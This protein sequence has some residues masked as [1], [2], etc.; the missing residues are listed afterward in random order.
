MYIVWKKRLFLLGIVLTIAS[1][2]NLAPLHIPSTLYAAQL[3][4]ID[5]SPRKNVSH[6]HLPTHMPITQTTC[7][8]SARAAV[9][10]PLK[11]GKRQNLLYTYNTSSNGFLIR[12]DI[13]SGKKTTVLNLNNATISDARISP[14]GQFILFVTQ[15]SSQLALQMVRVDGQSLQ[16]LYCVPNNTE[17]INFIDDL[18]WSPDQQQLLFR[19]SDP[20]GAKAAPSLKL[21]NLTHGSLQTVL[22]PSDKTGYIPR[23]WPTHDLVYMQGYALD[24]SDTVPPHDVYVLNLSKK[25][26]QRIASIAGYDWDLSLTP[27][28]KNLLLGQGVGPSTS[29]TAPASQSYQWA[30]CIWRQATGDLCQPH[31]CCHADMCHLN[32]NSALCTL[33]EDSSGTRNGLWKINLDGSGLTHL[34]S[35][36]KILSDQHTLWSTISRDERMYAVVNYDSTANNDKGQTTVLYGSLNGGRTTVVDMTD[37]G[38]NPEIVGW[39]TL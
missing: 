7:P 26:V 29:G 25:S 1:F 19:V 4:L 18:L 6:P 32:E 5:K 37:V 39:T 9:R 15:V 14:D 13:R 30:T 12:Y 23:V 28:G 34:T 21:L 36:G 31:L 22:A 2:F 35:D 20:T 33:E 8:S 24:A 27:D 10:V 16:T 11:E 3:T 38:N 17:P